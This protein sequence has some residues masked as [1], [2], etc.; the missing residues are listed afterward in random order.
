[1]AR[2]VENVM[3]I[4]DAVVSFNA[5]RIPKGS[6]ASASLKVRQESACMAVG[7][8]ASLGVI[9]LDVY[10][11]GERSSIWGSELSA[12]RALGTI[13]LKGGSESSIDVT[14]VISGDEVVSFVLRNKSPG[15]PAPNL[16]VT[17]SMKVWQTSG[18]YSASTPDKAAQ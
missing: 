12:G 17:F 3:D 4:R 18:V 1:M 9:E 11:V 16:L 5:G 13:Y 6:T 15:G 10:A 14:N 8:A 2:V 7:V